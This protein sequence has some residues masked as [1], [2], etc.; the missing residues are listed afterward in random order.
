MSRNYTPYAIFECEF[1]LKAM[2]DMLKNFGKV[3]K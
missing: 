3:P 1:L 2:N